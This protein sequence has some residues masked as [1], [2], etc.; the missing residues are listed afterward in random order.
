MLNDI[1]IEFSIEFKS[2]PKSV[3]YLFGI[4]TI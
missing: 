1:E 4:G 2:K 3:L